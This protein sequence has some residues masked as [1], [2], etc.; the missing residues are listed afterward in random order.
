MDEQLEERLLR[1]LKG[2]DSM[3][4]RELGMLTLDNYEVRIGNIQ[5]TI[6]FGK[7]QKGLYFPILVKQLE[8]F[9]KGKR[10]KKKHTNDMYPIYKEIKQIILRAYSD[11][12]QKVYI[13]IVYWRLVAEKIAFTTE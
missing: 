9:V 1:F 12:P 6:E 11:E 2:E 10:V 7:N 8:K 5:E 4:T 3:T 13:D